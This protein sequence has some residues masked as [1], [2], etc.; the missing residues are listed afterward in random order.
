MSTTPIAAVPRPQPL[1]TPGTSSSSAEATIVISPLVKAGFVSNT[2]HDHY[3][4]L[5]TIQ[6]AWSLPCLAHSCQANTLAEFFK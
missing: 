6:V 5:R 2:A 1:E 4:L 3:S